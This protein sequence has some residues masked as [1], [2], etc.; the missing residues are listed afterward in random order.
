MLFVDY[1]STLIAVIILFI[2]LFIYFFTFYELLKKFGENQLKSKNAIISWLLQGISSI[3]E[4][5]I[6]RKENNISKKFLDK[7]LIF[8]N[9]T[10][11]INIIQ[12]IPPSLFELLFVIITLSLVA[13]AVTTK[14]ENILPILSLYVVSFIRL[15][16]YLQTWIYI[17]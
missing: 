12:S 3:K 17:K 14:I 15:C 2:C 4:I 1:S 9:S 6:S 16:Q 7:V 10:V 13:F 11:K 8:E 5:K